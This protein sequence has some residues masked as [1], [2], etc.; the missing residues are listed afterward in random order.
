MIFAFVEG[1]LEV[2]VG[3]AV[4]LATTSLSQIASQLGSK[5]M[6]DIAGVVPLIGSMVSTIV[7]TIAAFD[8]GWSDALKDEARQRAA[9]ELEATLLEQCPVMVSSFNPSATS[10]GGVTPAD[11]FRTAYIS[12]QVGESLPPAISSIYILLCGAETQGVG[13]SK[14]EYD[15]IV[16]SESSRQGKSLGI[17]PFI[18]RRMW[19]LIKSIFA[20]CRDPRLSAE[21]IRFGDQGKS[22]FAILQDIVRTQWLKGQWNKDF[23]L[24]LSRFLGNEYTISS[25]YSCGDYCSGVMAGNCGDYLF[26]EQG[27]EN[28]QRIW[29]S[30]LEDHFCDWNPDGTCRWSAVPSAEDLAVLKRKK[31]FN[32]KRLPRTP[33]LILSPKIADRLE[34][35]LPYRRKRR[36]YILTGSVLAGGAALFAARHLIRKRSSRRV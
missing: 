18:Q 34:G 25:S 9:A 27:V 7:G 17:E 31:Q 29:Q 3:S 35:T 21:M 33:I 4:D 10:S 30:V 20:S 32:L 19:S 22:A 12:A 2:I 6:S 14:V 16:N 24:A 11:V 26:L 13:F 36:V 15:K 28:A 23:L 1:D 5:M 8:T